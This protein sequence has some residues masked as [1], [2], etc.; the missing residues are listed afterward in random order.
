[1]HICTIVQI[2]K[3]EVRLSLQIQAGDSYRKG[4]RRTKG[5]KNHSRFSLGIGP[6][7]G[8]HFVHVVKEVGTG[9][10]VWLKEYRTSPCRYQKGNTGGQVAFRSTRTLIQLD[11]DDSIPVFN[12]A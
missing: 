11:H 1:M 2:V 9:A 3:L 4:S 5:C 6:I 10:L 8:L 12:L 7:T